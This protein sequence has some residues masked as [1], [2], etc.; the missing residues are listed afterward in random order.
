M[1][2]EEWFRDS[3]KNIIRLHVLLMREG[4]RQCKS[5]PW[6]GGQELQELIDQVRLKACEILNLYPKYKNK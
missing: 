5:V 3:V 1:N 6:L 2:L 4:V